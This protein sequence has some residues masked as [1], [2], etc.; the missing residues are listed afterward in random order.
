MLYWYLNL[1]R[2]PD[3]NETQLAHL[4][5]QQ[6]PDDVVTRIEAKDRESYSSPM[7]LAADAADD[8]FPEFQK[9]PTRDSH[10]AFWALNWTYMRTLKKI[11][12]QDQPVCLA[13]D[14]WGTSFSYEHL[15]KLLEEIPDFDIAQVSWNVH[16]RY[17]T[18]CED[19]SEHWRR[20][21]PSTGM[22]IVVFSPKGAKALLT[23][24]RKQPQNAAEVII[25]LMAVWNDEI[26]IY[27]YKDPAGAIVGLD[28]VQNDNMV[29]VCYQGNYHKN[30]EHVSDRAVTEPKPKKV[31]D[32][33]KVN[34]LYVTPSAYNT[35][36][37]AGGMGTKTKA[38]LAAWGDTGTFDTT[39]DVLGT[40]L[41]NY[42]V[43]IIELLGF[44]N[45]SFHEKIEKL[46]ACGVPK[47]VYGS[48]SEVF[49]WTGNELSALNK[50]I[51][52]WIP[53]MQWQKHYFQDFG[54][55]V[56]DVVYEPIDTDLFR[57]SKERE[58]SIIA[59][60]AI[61][62]EKQSDFFIQ[63]F[64]ALQ[65]IKNTYKTVYL[66]SADL[67][68]QPP[69]VLDLELEHALK[70]VTD[71]FHGA[72]KQAKVAT[73]I[74]KASVGVLNPF[75]ETCNRFSMELMAGGV[76]QVCGIH[77]CY[78]ERPV[79][80]RFETLDECINTLSEMTNGFTAAPD[81]ELG[82]DAREYAEEYFSYEATLT[83]LNSI[84]RRVL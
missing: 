75:Y 46:G 76:P 8:G 84:L 34:I 24:C 42:D 74:G 81:K 39:E 20:G 27:S 71:V 64:T 2:R 9:I 55:A 70:A 58:L 78:D 66:G 17:Q 14:D 7:I 4:K 22:D 49:R 31:I 67:W 82:T 45:D 23:E 33:T 25:R 16:D 26:N 36:K 10:I 62:Y 51:S 13:L 68:H 29:D 80:A 11:A 35:R 83:Q 73:A 38:L 50:I 65:P 21:A 63:L 1:E 12:E 37:F 52:L 18:V 5:K 57:P 28:S 30:G 3:R 19:A 61:S 48:D 40:D 41:D 77:I 32:L 44:R 6:Y 79:D 47:I 56:T 69:K 43:I 72:V 54:F 15:L 53:N 59:G 60:G